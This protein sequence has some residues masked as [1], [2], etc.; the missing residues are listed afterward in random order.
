MQNVVF[1]VVLF[2]SLTASVGVGLGVAA[3]GV[4]GDQDGTRFEYGMTSLRLSR[5][6]LPLSVITR[7]MSRASAAAPATVHADMRQASFVRRGM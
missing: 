1:P 3:I 6:S 2:A 4:Q 7:E 5:G